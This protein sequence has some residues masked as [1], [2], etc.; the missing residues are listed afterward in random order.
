MEEYRET[1]HPEATRIARRNLVLSELVKAENIQASEEEIEARVLAMVRSTDH[2][3]ELSE[4][5]QS[6]VEVL[7][8]GSG[9]TMILSQIL[10]EKTVER[11]LAIVRGEEVPAPEAVPAETPDATEPADSAEDVAV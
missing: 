2:D 8:Q 3:G 5:A 10:M 6:L 7:S 4:S 1:L 11:L 9:R